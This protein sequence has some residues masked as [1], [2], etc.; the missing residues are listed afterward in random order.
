MPGHVGLPP[1]LLGDPAYPL[2]PNVMR[3]FNS[4]AEAKRVMFNN[5]LRSTTRLSVLSDE[6][7]L[8]R[9]VD[10]D[11]NFAVKLVY[12][13]FILHNFCECNRADGKAAFGS[14]MFTS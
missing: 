13:C 7:I 5:K 6:S 10:V 14:V 3:E 9:A 2:L 8:N 1:S 4:C 11:L 12:A